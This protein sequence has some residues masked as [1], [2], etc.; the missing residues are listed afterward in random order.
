MATTIFMVENR[1]GGAV[2]DSSQR[3]RLCVDS[4]LENQ[5]AVGAA[6]AEGVRERIV[7][8]HRA[9]VVRHVIQIA[10]RI[11]ILVD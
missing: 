10:V 7:D 3:S 8:L 5:A 6:E 4:R 2:E 1:R 9:R 11:G